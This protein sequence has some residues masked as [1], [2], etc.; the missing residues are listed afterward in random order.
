MYKKIKH[1]TYEI[2]EAAKPGDILS[3]VFDIF[4]MALIFINVIAVLLDTF[5]LPPAVAKASKVIEIISVMIFTVEYLL[6]LWTCEYKYPKCSPAKCLIKYVFSFM[7]I[8]DL[9]AI[10]PFYLPMIISIDL[11]VLRMLRIFRLMR[12]FKI[13]RY[14]KALALIGQV[15]KNKSGQLISSIAVVFVLILIASVIMYN[16]EHEAQPEQF[17]N[18]F[19]S[20]W[21]AI[22]TLTTVGYGDIY[23]ITTIGKMLSATIALLGIGLVAVPTGIITAGFSELVEKEKNGDDQKCYCPYCGHKLD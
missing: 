21:W 16:V 20:M 6:R 22:A 15:F 5:D 1:R 17:T 10:I 4:I 13:N 11:R 14:T 12:I 18:V 7:A 23:P 3:K 9:L 2:I 8:I 19:Q